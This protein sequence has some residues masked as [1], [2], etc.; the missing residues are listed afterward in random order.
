MSKIETFFFSTG[1]YEHIRSS[2][3]LELPHRTT[4]NQYTGFTDVGTGFNPDV[5]MRF[6]DDVNYNSLHE[7]DKNVALLFDEMKIKAGLV[8]D[9]A[10]GKLVGFTELG[11]LNEELDQF[12]RMIDGN[13]EKE[14]ATHIIC[15]MARGL[16]KHYNYPIG[17]Y[18]SLGFDSDQLYPIVWE[19]VRVLEM[20]GFMVRTFVSDGASNG[21]VL[22]NDAKPMFNF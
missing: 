13:K 20:C 19:A 15:F 11:D 5:L 12:E 18:S 6:R 10:S 1:T 21:S 22:D 3:F 4:L 17:Y 14:C 16:F 8:Y 7:C 2:G 9:R